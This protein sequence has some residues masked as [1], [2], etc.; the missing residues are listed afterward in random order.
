MLELSWEPHATVLANASSTGG[1]ISA[2]L[3]DL[4][5]TAEI[6][7]SK[8]ARVV[9]ARDTRPSGPALVA[10]LEDGLMAMG[11][12]A[13]NAGVITAPMIHYLVRAINT[14][15]TKDSYG[16]DTEEGYYT[17]FSSAFNE[18]IAGRPPRSPLVID[19]ANGVGAPA[20]KIL[21]RY[22]QNSL[23]IE[24]ENTAF[25]IPGA[26]NNACGADF[27]KVNQKLPPSLVN[28]RLLPLSSASS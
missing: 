7:I 1:L 20:A 19:C 14:K 3:H 24:L 11:A 2:L 18:L 28:T 10:A 22:L 26:L 27:V 4:I 21:S 16:D 23:P 13:R 12:E 17:K 8:L 9:Y 25:D 5:K 6:A 15:G